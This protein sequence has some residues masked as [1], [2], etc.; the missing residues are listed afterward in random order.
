[1]RAFDPLG[2]LSALI[3]GSVDFVIIGGLAARL[4][5]SPSITDDLDI[6]H[7]KEPSNLERLAGALRRMSAKLRG[8]DDVPLKLDAQSLK[9]GENFTFITDF[10]PLDCIA[11][12]AGVNGYEDLIRTAEMTDMNGLTLAVASLEDLIR[13]KRAAGRP[14]DLIELEILGALRDEIEGK[15]NH[16]Q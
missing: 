3:D 7:S 5:G 6:C 15:P 1:M 2:A 13:M 14:Q 11:L 12:P 9:N 4:R 8:A 10:G 16:Q